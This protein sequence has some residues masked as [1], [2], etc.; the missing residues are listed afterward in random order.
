MPVARASSACTSNW[1]GGT[2]TGLP[3]LGIVGAVNC[4]QSGGNYVCSYAQTLSLLFLIG[5]SNVRARAPNVGQSFRG[6]I[7]QASIVVDPPHGAVSNFCSA[8][9]PQ[10]GKG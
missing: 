1:T 2:V 3:L 9:I 4:A 6:P 8:W 7:S 10:P 5:R